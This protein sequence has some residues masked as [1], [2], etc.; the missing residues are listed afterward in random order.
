MRNSY[1]ILVLILSSCL[2]FDNTS[3]PSYT[4]AVNEVVIVIDD[5]LWEGACGDSIR[6]YLNSEVPGLSWIEPLFDIVQINTS[7]FGRI[8]ETHR[9]LIIV[10]KGEK[11]NIYFNTKP[12]SRNQWFCIIEYE[13]AS[14]LQKVLGE[15]LPIISHQIEQKE[16]ERYDFVGPPKKSLPS[17]AKKFNLNFGLPNKYKS[18]L[19]TNG[20]SWFEYNPPDKE[21]IKGVF[22]YEYAGV[23][24]FN[25]T[26]L[27]MA[28]DSVLKQFVLGVSDSSY[29]TTEHQYAPH[30][31]IHN[32]DNLQILRVK[33][34]WK[35]S[36]AF[37]GG[38]FV[39]NFICDTA[40]N[41]V[42]ALEGFLFSPG[43]DKRNRMK[44][45]E[46]I[47]SDFKIRSSK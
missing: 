24:P 22:V 7:D 44:E 39:S 17:A 35:M 32:H 37:M 28:R 21:I 42:L 12:Y 5:P 30:V 25:A 23:R 41:R 16:Q 31:S 47:I 10:Q 20:F 18:V 38:S 19:D 34:L 11:T 2:S 29:M 40:N 3:L 15:Y 27:L 26:T 43:E 1:L 9:N 8:F 33:G 46:W 45:L 6:H 36:N 14:D 4:G 13:T